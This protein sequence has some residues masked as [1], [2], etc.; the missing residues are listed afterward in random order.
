LRTASVKPAVEYAV[1]RLK[2][3]DPEGQTPELCMVTWVI[4][5]TSLN[6]ASSG[7]SAVVVAVMFS[8]RLFVVGR[9][10]VFGV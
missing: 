8:D 7:I 1:D 5:V 10:G 3:I 6:S 2:R 9:D 4:F